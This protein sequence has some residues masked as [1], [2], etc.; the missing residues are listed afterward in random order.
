MTFMG[1][2]F[3]YSDKFVKTKLKQKG[4]TY[5]S[6]CQRDKLAAEACFLH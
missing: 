4:S 6:I 2:K 3:G 5:N 1:N